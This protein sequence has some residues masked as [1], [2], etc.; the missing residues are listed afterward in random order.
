MSFFMQ[1]LIRRQPDPQGRRWL[2]VPYDQITDKIGPLSKGNPKTL[3]IVLVESRGP[4]R[5]TPKTPTEE[6]NQMC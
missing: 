5:T 6:R 2:Y 4:L 1:A 3:G